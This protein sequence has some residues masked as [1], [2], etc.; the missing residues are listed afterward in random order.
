MQRSHNRANACTARRAF[1]V[2]FLRRPAVSMALVVA[3]APTSRTIGLLVSLV[4]VSLSPLLSSRCTGLVHSLGQPR[5]C[6]VGLRS[7]EVMF[8]QGPHMMAV[9]W[10]GPEFSL[11]TAYLPLGVFVV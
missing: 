10:M 6:P 11:L 1:S 9:S 5:L 2:L 3:R 8:G 4:C 7:S